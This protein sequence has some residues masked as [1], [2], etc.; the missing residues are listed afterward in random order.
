MHKVRDPA[1]GKSGRPEVGKGKDGKEGKNQVL[2]VAV[3]RVQAQCC[4]LTVAGCSPYK[5]M[6]GRSSGQQ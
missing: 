5:H 3:L 4:T 2:L 1:N 6:R